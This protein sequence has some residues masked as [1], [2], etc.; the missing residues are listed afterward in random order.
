MKL[1]NFTD[2]M[3]LFVAQERTHRD[4]DVEFHVYGE[5]E[6]SYLVVE[7]TEQ[8]SPRMVN[9][10]VFSSL[11]KENPL[12]DFFCFL[13]QCNFDQDGLVKK[14]SSA[15]YIEDGVNE[16]ARFDQVEVARYQIKEA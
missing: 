16:V 11:N 6:Q 7:V 2:W 3:K 8:R 4:G 10:Y 12:F 14:I 15:T 13:K 5:G 1:K 9:Q